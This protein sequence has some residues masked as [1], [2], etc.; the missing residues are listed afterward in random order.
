MRR[1]SA[2]RNLIANLKIKKDNSTTLILHQTQIKM[3]LKITRK[4]R[5]LCSFIILTL[6]IIN[7]LISQDTTKLVSTFSIETKGAGILVSYKE[8][9]NDIECISCLF[10]TI[11]DNPINHFAI[12]SGLTHKLTINEKFIFETGIF[13][14]ERS[15]SGG[16]NTVS[17]WAVYPK[18]LLSGRD[19]LNI[20]NRAIQYKLMGGDFWNQD[21]DDM[22]RIHN[23][24]YQGLNG[25]LTF[26][27]YSIGFLIVG[28]L[29]TNVE[30]GLHQLHKYYIKRKVDKFSAS[31]FFSENQ[32]TSRHSLPQDYNVGNTLEYRISKNTIFQSQIELRLNEQLGTSFAMGI[33]V[34]GEVKSLKFVGKLKYYQAGFNLGYGTSAILNAGEQPYRDGDLY[35]GEQL[36]PLKNFYRTYSQWG[37]YTQQQNRDLLGLE[38]NVLWEKVITN[39][40]YFFSDIDLNI[41]GNP[42]RKVGKTIPLYSIGIRNKYFDFL[43]TEF[44]ITNKFMNIDTFYQTFQ[45]SKNPFFGGRIIL[46]LKEIKLR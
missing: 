28:D 29:A 4:T 7:P 16:N 6:V 3:L 35:V 11:S 25:E 37:N 44:Y 12:Y 1:T 41:I 17:N 21:F 8:A 36:Y 18:I 22:L 23:L 33:G 14:E 38:L 5:A 27:N 19:T 2:T 20:A 32:L 42:Q 9:R 30:L 43:K 40:V 24:D 10:E 46:D 39:N 15:F 13:L 45:A 31:I 26:K 34:S